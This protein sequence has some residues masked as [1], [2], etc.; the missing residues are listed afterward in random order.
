MI[1]QQELSKVC[2]HHC[3]QGKQWT[4]TH[5]QKGSLDGDILQAG[6]GVGRETS[7]WSLLA[8]KLQELSSQ[9]HV[10]FGLFSKVNCLVDY[11]QR[12]IIIL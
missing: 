6:K 7:S 4:A 12:V 8:Q 10:T 9:P 3:L 11:T 5:F 2:A 1:L